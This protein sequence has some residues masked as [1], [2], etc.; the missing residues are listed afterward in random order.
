MGYPAIYP[1]YDTKFEPKAEAIPVSA[2][3]LPEFLYD[4]ELFYGKQ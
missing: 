1:M 4:V 2:E 3:G